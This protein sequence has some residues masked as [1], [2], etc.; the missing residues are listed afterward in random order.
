MVHVNFLTHLFGQFGRNVESFGFAIDEKRNLKL[1]M[2]IL[3]VGTMAVGA[4]AGALALDERAWKH[5]AKGTEA[6]DEF[7]TQ[8]EIGVAR[9]LTDTNYSVRSRIKQGP[10]KICKIAMNGYLPRIH[11]TIKGLDR[12]AEPRYGIVA[13]SRG[14]VQVLGT[15]PRLLARMRPPL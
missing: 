6:A 7:A 10:A 12:S 8:F 5:L 14:A 9:H 3:A 15:T 2:Q 1:R 13:G 11:C 4:T